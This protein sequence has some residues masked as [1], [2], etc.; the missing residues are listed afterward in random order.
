VLDGE[1]GAGWRGRFVDFGTQPVAAASIGQV[2]RARLRDGRDLAIKVQYPGVAQ[3]I[4]SD[5][6]NVAS[7][8]RLSGSARGT[9]CRA[10]A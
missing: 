5:V 6:D 1:W 7:L 2:H 9:R 8:L 3:S 10:A 4:D